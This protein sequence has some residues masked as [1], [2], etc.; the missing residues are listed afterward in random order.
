[1]PTRFGCSQGSTPSPFGVLTTGAARR[2]ATRAIFA[3]SATE[4]PPNFITTVA[5]AST[6]R[7]VRSGS[8]AW[9]SCVI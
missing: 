2:S 4:L 9:E 3:G 7:G 1:M 6:S 5:G 8:A